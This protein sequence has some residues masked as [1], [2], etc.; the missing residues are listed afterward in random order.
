MLLCSPPLAAATVYRTVDDN[1]VVSFS[2]TRPPGETTV[3]TLHIEAPAPQPDSTGQERLQAMRET[4]DRMAAD[5]R[6]RE[7]HRAELRQ[8]QAQSQPQYVTEY[9]TP[10]LYTGS[11]GGYYRRNHYRPGN[12]Q[13]P[14]IGPRPEHPDVRPPLR[15][16]Q[17]RA[18]A[19]DF[20]GYNNYPA[21]LI[22]RSYPPPVRRA[23]ST[24]RR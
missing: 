20:G 24:P 15:P 14:G 9:L 5:R 3:E 4:T 8:L 12:G 23:F 6:E 10:P 19:R 7:K 1:G 11:Y 22:R 16:P 13:R 21:S 18:A 17:G 2:D